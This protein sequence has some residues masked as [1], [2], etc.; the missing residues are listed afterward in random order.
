MMTAPWVGLASAASRT[1]DELELLRDRLRQGCFLVILALITGLFMDPLVAPTKVLPLYSVKFFA[2]LTISWLTRGASSATSIVDLKRYLRVFVVVNAV[3]FSVSPM[4]AGYGW[5][6]FVTAGLGSL[7]IAA[8]FPLTVAEQ[9][10]YAVLLLAL[11]T[12]PAMVLGNYSNVALPLVSA[13]VC[14]GMSVFF[15]AQNERHRKYTEATLASFR[16]NLDRLRLLTEHLHGILWLSDPT[17]AHL[18]VSGRF[19]EIWGHDPELLRERPDAWVDWVHPDDRDEVRSWLQHA[20]ALSD[21]P[22][23]YRVQQASGGIRWIRD[24]MFSIDGMQGGLWFVGRLSLDVTSEKDALAAIR[25]RELAR[26]IQAAVEEE[27]MRMARELH[28]ELGQALTGIKLFL[29]M[30]RR[31]HETAHPSV[32]HYVGVCIQE[33]DKAMEGVQSMIHTLRPPALDDF[34]LF[35]ALRKQVDTFAKRTGIR[36]ELDIPDQQPPLSEEE[37]TTVFRIAQESLTNVARH[38]EATE[39]MVQLGANDDGLHLRIEDNGKGFEATRE[40][41]GLRGMRERAALINGA[42]QIH[43]RQLGGTVVELDIPRGGGTEPLGP[44]ARHVLAAN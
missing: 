35:A 43:P 21:E 33:V 10:N 22:C 38:A 34:G 13:V 29:A 36:C 9:T 4:I 41:F 37:I 17:G 19:T 7:A 39:V 12:L 28:D 44:R 3:F 42:L 25:M 8:L 16:T 2:I 40:N 26:T 11:A 15:T 5:H 32:G 27:R 6:S 23:E 31:S 20:P 1:L 30:A 24:T 18:Y 14:S